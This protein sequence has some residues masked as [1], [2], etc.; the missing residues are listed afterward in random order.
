MFS[1]VRGTP[2]KTEH[3]NFVRHTLPIKLVLRKKLLGGNV[4]LVV[5]YQKNTTVKKMLELILDK[6]RITIPPPLLDH[7]VTLRHRA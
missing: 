2:I 1:F 3:Q 5:P 7:G 4:S 6:E